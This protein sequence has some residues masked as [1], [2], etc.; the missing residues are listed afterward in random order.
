MRAQPSTWVGPVVVALASA[1]AA[2][3]FLVGD[4]RA[5]HVVLEDDFDDPSG[6]TLVVQ[7]D[8]GRRLQYVLG[9][10]EISIVAKDTWWA[11]IASGGS[12]ED[13]MRVEVDARLLRGSPTD[14]YTGVGCGQGRSTAFLFGVSP[15]GSYFIARAPEGDGP[16]TT[17]DSGRVSGMAGGSGVN[18]LEAECV[19][20]S[21]KPTELRLAVNGRRAGAARGRGI[22]S[23]DSAWVI[24]SSSDA[25]S[26]ARFD[27]LVVSTR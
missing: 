18:H 2:A 20:H 8:V 9:E 3:Y 5:W 17:L 13:A 16:W 27:D 11:S 26:I 6:G 22:D 21:G 25:K 7:E 10:Y 23:F 14:D 19:G 15:D 4:A 12:S 24:S 1:A